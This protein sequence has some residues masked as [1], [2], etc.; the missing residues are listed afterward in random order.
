MK[1]HRKTKPT[2]LSVNISRQRGTCK[3][4]VK[5][6]ELTDRGIEADAHAGQWHRQVSLLSKETI[7]TFSA[8]VGRDFAP[9]DFAENITT[10]GLDLSEVSLLDE[11]TICKTRL[12]VTQIGKACHPGGCSVFKQVGKCVMPREGIFCRVRSGGSIAAGDAIGVY[13]HNLSF[14]VLTLSDRASRG[15]YE[16]RSGPRITA[17]LNEFFRP[18]RWRQEVVNYLLPD[19][20]EKLRA[21]L[22]AARE[23]GVDVVI[24]TGGT[25]VGPR[26][27]TPDVVAPMCDKLL[28][29]IM[30]YVR[31]KYGAQIP[32]ALLSRSIAGVMGRTIVYALPGS[33][34]AVEQYIGEILKTIEHLILTVHGID[35]H[36]G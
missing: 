10:W 19:D 2:V 1:Q 27:I 22:V 12:E 17:I 29:G 30:D 3:R 21:F 32:T 8:D 11:F 9:G 24:T 34:H 15:D 23:D 18:K 4:P 25:G 20:P 16:D 14:R 31:L 35:P 13:P 5:S 26:D 28:P 6:I 33:V 7:D 36:A